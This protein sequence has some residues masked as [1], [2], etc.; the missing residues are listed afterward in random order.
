MLCSLESGRA[1]GQPTLALQRPCKSCWNGAPTW[2][3]KTCAATPHCTWP[4][5]QA[6]CEPRLL[7]VNAEKFCTVLPAKCKTMQELLHVPHAVA[8]LSVNILRNS[9]YISRGR[10][11]LRGDSSA[12]DPQDM[13]GA[14]PGK[15]C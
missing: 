11:V 4:L 13:C 2:R 9:A 7:L 10:L 3:P 12:L 14:A 1:I 5:L 15:G 8:M 6:I